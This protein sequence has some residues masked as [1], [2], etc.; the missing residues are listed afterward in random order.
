MSETL[1]LLQERVNTGE[2]VRLSD[3]T[4]A[5]VAGLTAI[6]VR[7]TAI[8]TYPILTPSARSTNEA[9]S[10]CYKP[11]WQVS[12]KCSNCEVA[13]PAFASPIANIVF[14]AFVATINV[15]FP[16]IDLSCQLTQPRWFIDTYLALDIT[17]YIDFEAY[18][19]A[20]V[21]AALMQNIRLLAK[22]FGR[23]RI[24]AMPKNIR[25]F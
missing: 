20:P 25:G 13:Y 18:G 19:V 12:A 1:Q 3:E 24:A 8:I 5:A 14:C 9:T 17:Y 23:R 2:E 11:K 7:D 4:I 15:P 21:Y 6:E 22:H 10:A 16:H